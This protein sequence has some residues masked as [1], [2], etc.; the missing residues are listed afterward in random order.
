[1]APEVRYL[2]AF[3]DQV[4]LPSAAGREFVRWYYE[5]SPPVADYL[6]RH[7]GLR[8]LVR[9]ALAPLVALSKMIVSP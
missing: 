8:A 6:R 7:D 1:M 4:L 9:G 3:R 5:F 2:R